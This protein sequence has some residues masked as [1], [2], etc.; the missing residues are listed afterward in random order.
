MNKLPSKKHFLIFEKNTANLRIERRA[1]SEEKGRQSRR[2]FA[3]FTFSSL[4]EAEK[5]AVYLE[6]RPPIGNKKN[7][8]TAFMNH[9]GKY[10]RMYFV[11]ARDAPER[12]SVEAGRLTVSC[13]NIHNLLLRSDKS[14]QATSLSYPS[15]YLPTTPLLPKHI[16]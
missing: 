4:L 8:A 7:P 13:R 10:L 1:T 15:A 9:S 3:A 5:E 16:G 14:P 2:R 6:A 11:L 12:L